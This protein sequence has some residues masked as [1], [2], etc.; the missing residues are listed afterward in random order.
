MLMR[1]VCRN[2]RFCALI[3][4]SVLVMGCQKDRYSSDL[5]TPSGELATTIIDSEYPAVVL[6]VAPGGAGICTGTFISE[7]AVLTAAHCLADS[8]EYTVVSSFGTFKTSSKRSLGPGQVDD[9][10]DIG[11]LIFSS[12]KASR[13]AG[14]VYDIHDK[15]AQGD[16][17][18]LIGYG[19]NNI[20]TRRGS[21]VKRTGTNAVAGIDDYIEFLT[22]ISTS[23][24]NGAR[25][26]FGP[27][28]RAAS[29]FGDSGGPAAFEQGG[30]LYVAGVTHAGGQ[31]GSNQVS[32]Y[33]N[34]ATQSENRSFLRDLNSEFSL[35][36][37][38]I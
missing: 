17:L 32:Q 25:G 15:V 22:P 1:Y 18:R 5:P 28:N 4:L 23:G 9:P 7:K 3:V 31:E 12:A 27:A 38:G 35:D 36:I 16:V 26:I 33:A 30:K 8:G 2:A 11:L 19:C 34:V 37:R 13:A 20:T 14:Q 21:G 6:V 29:C 10:Q 24:S